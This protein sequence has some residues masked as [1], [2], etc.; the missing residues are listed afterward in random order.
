MKKKVLATVL[1]AAMVLAATGCGGNSA[2][3]TG[4]ST[5]SSGSQASESTGDDFKFAFATSLTVENAD[6]GEEQ[7]AALEI[8]VDQ[9]NAAGGINGKQ[10]VFDAFDDQGNP[11]EAQICAQKIVSDGNY[12]FALGYNSSGRF[13]ASN[14][15]YVQAGMPVIVSSGTASKVTEQGFENCVRV[16]ARDD[17]DV[18]TIIAHAAKELD[19]KKCVVIVD[20]AE[21]EIS[22]YDNVLPYLDEYG[23]EVI[24]TQ[25]AETTERD[26]NAI[27]TNWKSMDFDTIIFSQNYDHLA[28]FLNQAVELG[29]I[30]DDVNMVCIN[31][32]VN[33]AAFTDLVGNNAD[34][35]TVVAAYNV[36][37]Q[38]ETYIE[39]AKQFEEKTGK[40]AGE[41][42]ITTYVAFQ[43][44]ADAYNDFGATR[45]NLIETIKANK[46]DTISGE[47]YFDEKGDNEGCPGGL[48]LIQDGKIDIYDWQN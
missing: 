27:I 6:Y 10:V 3:T 31:G 13:L 11:Q 19:A 29:L 44:A 22:S 24:D 12:Q 14:P 32:S 26:Y 17:T 5:G 9:I 39:F 28:L 4:G 7:L 38:D 47:A 37:A 36:D 48:C 1:A 16:C 25:Y 18:S 34:G 43:V 30:T 8:A 41:A 33:T 15:T 23:I 45:E 40:K 20:N 21:G 46:F 2:Q 42:A 35:M